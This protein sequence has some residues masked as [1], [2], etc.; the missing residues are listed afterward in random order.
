M[1]ARPKSNR[2]NNEN[3]SGMV[4]KFLKIYA[5]KH[6]L[7]ITINSFRFSFVTACLKHT[8]THNTQRLI[9]HKDIRSTMQYSRYDLTPE[10]QE[11]ILNKM[12]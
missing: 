2:K 11:D 9:G 6:N 7:K 8:T 5:E 1:Y 3:F 10:L 12:F 4:N